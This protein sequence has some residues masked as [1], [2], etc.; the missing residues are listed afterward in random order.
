MKPLDLEY[1][2]HKKT[3]SVFDKVRLFYSLWIIIVGAKSETFAQH[4]HFGERRKRNQIYEK[5]PS[6]ELLI[7]D[8][9]YQKDTLTIPDLVK[10]L[11]ILMK[12]EYSP[13]YVSNQLKN[14]RN[15]KKR[16]GFSQ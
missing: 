2:A 13:D 15:K 3:L 14:K 6:K 16:R 10:A 11:D 12:T 8:L 4:T 1:L 9:Q 5:L 7:E